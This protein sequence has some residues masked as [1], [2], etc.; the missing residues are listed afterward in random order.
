MTTRNK[1]SEQIQRLYVRQFDRANLAPI[2]DRREV[3][4]LVDQVANTLLSIELKTAARIGDMQIPSCM[5][6]TYPAQTVANNSG[7]YSAMLPAFPI[8]LPMD[9]GVWGVYVE[10][11]GLACIPVT[12]AQ[13]DLIAGLTDESA[14]EGQ[15]GYVVEGRKVRFLTNPSAATVTIKILIVD[16]GSLTDDDPYPVPSEMESLIITEVLKLLNSVQKAPEKIN[17]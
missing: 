1:I 15:V 9:V 7:V 2:L 13:W 4:L 12:S 10:P 8:K 3:R 16:I 5:I 14:L 11:S 17:G 6:A